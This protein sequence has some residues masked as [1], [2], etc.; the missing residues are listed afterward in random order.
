MV[1]R[2]K[3]KGVQVIIYKPTLEEV[4]TFFGSLIVNDLVKLKNYLMASF[5]ISMIILWKQKGKV[6]TRDLLERD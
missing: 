2:I 5:L 4:T 6:H 1:R 3:A